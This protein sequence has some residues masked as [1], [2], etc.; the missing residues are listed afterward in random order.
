M[1]PVVAEALSE[2]RVFRDLPKALLPL[3]VSAARVRAVV[4]GE[5]LIEHGSASSA[6]FLVLEGQLEVIRPRASETHDGLGT[7]RI[8]ELPPGS[9]FGELSLVTTQSA[10]A[11]VR[12]QT[13]VRVVELSGESLFPL[14]DACDRL[15]RIFY[16]N[17]LEL[18]IERV[19]EKDEEMELLTSVL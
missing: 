17:L 19:K 8:N 14:L 4:A 16:R 3:I 9:C 2:S 13:A 12:A 15:A 6:L 1:N 11:T 10:T 18:L 7:M 5:T